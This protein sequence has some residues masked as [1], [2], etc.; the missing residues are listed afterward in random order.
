MLVSK[1]EKEKPVDFSIVLD[2]REMIFVEILWLLLKIES[3]THATSGINAAASY[4]LA[5]SI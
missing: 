5:V 1:S 3:S 2:I 4:L